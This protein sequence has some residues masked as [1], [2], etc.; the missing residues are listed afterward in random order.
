MTHEDT[1]S[2]LDRAKA[3]DRGAFDALCREHAERL[4]SF[5]RARLGPGLRGKVEPEDVVQE[6]LLRAFQSIGA[7]R[8]GDDRSLASWLLS[9]AEHLIWNASQ[10]RSFREGVLPLDLTSGAATPSQG[11]RREER[12]ERLKA[13]LS[14]L[15]PE[16]RQAIL[17]AKIDGLPAK[18]IARRLGRSEDAV[19]QLLSRGLRQLRRRFGD[20][21]SLGLPP[22]R[23][24][25]SGEGHGAG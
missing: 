10:K 21:E 24:L 17:L 25:E 7:F 15:K 23:G 9:I 5:V 3:G 13:S 20:T 14:S 6:T 1:E 16:Q 12:L 18:E 22:D 19:K 2:L 8:G 11:L 4:E